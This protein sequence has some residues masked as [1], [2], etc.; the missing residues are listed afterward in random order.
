MQISL[1]PHGDRSACRSK[2][3]CLSHWPW[4][5]LSV[6]VFQRINCTLRLGPERNITAQ[7]LSLARMAYRMHGMVVIVGE[8]F[9]DIYRLCPTALTCAQPCCSWPIFCCIKW[10][11]WKPFIFRIFIVSLKAKNHAIECQS[12]NSRWLDN[13]LPQDSRLDRCRHFSRKW[14]AYFSKDRKSVV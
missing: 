6:L 5:N 4:S 14:R 2:T 12:S 1:S 8:D 7:S 11:P 3:L 9:V 10:F 13:E